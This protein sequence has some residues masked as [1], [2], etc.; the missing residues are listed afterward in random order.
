MQLTWVLLHRCEISQLED[1]GVYIQVFI[2]NLDHFGAGD[3]SLALVGSAKNNLG[4]STAKLLAMHL[5]GYAPSH[6]ATANF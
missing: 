6:Y 5:S 1:C 3:F 2:F 4:S